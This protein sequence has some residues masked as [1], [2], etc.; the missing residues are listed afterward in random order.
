MKF[1]FG[2][3]SVLSR[4]FSVVS[5]F[6]QTLFELYF[7]LWHFAAPYLSFYSFHGGLFGFSRFVNCEISS[8]LA[9][10]PFSSTVA[11][12]PVWVVAQ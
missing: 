2:D 7:E 12:G 8:F 1:S 6:G 3:S 10:V 5:A 9:N 4:P 11:F